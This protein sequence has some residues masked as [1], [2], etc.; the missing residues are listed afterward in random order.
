[1]NQRALLVRAEIDT[2]LFSERQKD[3]AEIV[4]LAIG[5]FFDFLRIA[6]R[7]PDIRMIGDALDL[8]RNVSWRE[9]KIDKPS[10]NRAPWHGI[11]LRGLF[12]LGE[13]QA[14]GRFART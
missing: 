14:A 10:A 4:R 8:A 12:I 5:R 6:Q 11:E 1:S 9:N 7:P 2:H 3:A 13:G